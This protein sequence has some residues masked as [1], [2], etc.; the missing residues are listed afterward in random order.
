[1]NNVLKAC[2]QNNLRVTCMLS[3]L[4]YGWTSQPQQIT[5][6]LIR[7]TTEFG[8]PCGERTRSC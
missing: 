2:M 4:H 7:W 3:R 8:V 1:M 5:Q 6:H